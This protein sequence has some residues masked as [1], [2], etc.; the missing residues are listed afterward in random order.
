MSEPQDEA[1][2]AR[3]A[4][5]D[6]RIVFEEEPH[7]Q[8]AWAMEA[9]TG[10]IEAISPP[11]LQVWEFA[12]SPDGSRIAA[13]VSDHPY[14]WDWYLAR[15][16]VFDVGGGAATE[17]HRS[18]RQVARPAWSPDGRTIAFLTSTW[19]DRGYDSGAPMLVPADGTAAA[20]FATGEDDDVSD[21]GIHFDGDGRLVT[22]TNA[23]ASGAVTTIDPQNGERRTL[24]Q[25]RRK[26]GP[27]SEAR[28]AGGRI[29]YA[30]ILEDLDNPPEVHVGEVADGA[31]EWRRVTDVHAPWRDVIRGEVREL[32]W[33]GADGTPMQGFLYLPPGHRGGRLPLVTLVHGGP[34][35][36]IQFQ[37]HIGSGR[38]A[39][40]LADAGMAVF[41]P[42]FR[43][44]TGW[45][46]GF[47]EANIGDM[48]GEDFRDIMA[49]IDRLIADGVADGDRLGICGWSY[50][51]F[52]SAWAITQTDRFKAAV[53]GAAITDWR[54]FHG[55]SYLHSWDRLHYGGS[56]PYDPQ[57]AHARFSPMSHIRNASTPTLLLHGEL[58]WDVPVEQA[59]IL[60]RALKDL[61]VETRLVVYP[62]ASHMPS[63]LAHRLDLLARVCDW[64]AGHLASGTP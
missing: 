29:R 12:L 25:D 27:L 17:L 58:D 32:H 18:W 34:T 28:L 40:P 8:R 61:G 13:V 46:L 5:G 36:C 39:R 49:G 41:V 33:S 30:A 2:R 59:Y 7:R 48:G 10:A 19:S 64:M 16:A 35:S 31:L 6:D 54:S 9:S 53:A 26:V 37:F 55:R 52:M 15:L 22:T 63:E 11:G 60:H 50:G 43:G 3:I 21:S 45:G 38:W 51:G 57:S 62:R 56:D 14:E 42:N 20:A 23:H 1:T 44:S 24:W 4:A 47:A